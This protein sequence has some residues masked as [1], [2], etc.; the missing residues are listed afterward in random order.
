VTFN[1]TAMGMLAAGSVVSLVS[2]LLLFA[3]LTDMWH[4]YGPPEIWS[5]T[6]LGKAE[7]R[8]AAVSVWILAAIQLAVLGIT[9][10]SLLRNRRPGE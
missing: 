3:A 4:L 7:W 8:M 9:L 5:G 2:V 10:A 6:G 1:R